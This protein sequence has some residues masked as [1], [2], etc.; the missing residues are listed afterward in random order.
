MKLDSKLKLRTVAGECI[1]TLRSNGTDDMTRVISLNQTSKFLWETMAGKDFTVADV[2]DA[3]VAEYEIDRAVAEKDAAS[4][5]Q[6]LSEL[7]V[8][9]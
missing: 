6:K 3:L 4:W 8:L 5:V 9:E 7:G 1:I 2:A